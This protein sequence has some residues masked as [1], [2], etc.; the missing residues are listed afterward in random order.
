MRPAP[1]RARGGE[2]GARPR[3]GDAKEIPVVRRHEKE[4]TDRRRIEEILESAKVV[5]LAMVDGDEPYVVPM[6]F[7]YA[8]RCLYLHSAPAGRRRSN[9]RLWQ[10]ASRR[11][12]GHEH[13]T[14]VGGRLQGTR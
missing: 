10:C 5:H 6:Y 7:G 12:G 14:G 4:I 1:G 3:G 2:I 8:D 11:A 9:K 13:G